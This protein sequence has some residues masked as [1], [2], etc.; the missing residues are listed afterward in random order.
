VRLLFAAAVAAAAAAVAAAAAAA[1]AA[2]VAVAAAA[3]AAAAVAAAAVAAAAVAAASTV[4]RGKA[5]SFLS[6]MTP[7]FLLARV[8]PP[9]TA[10]TRGC[11]CFRGCVCG[12]RSTGGV[13]C[14]NAQRVTRANS[15]ALECTMPRQT[16]G[17]K[18]V[19]I[20]VAAQNGSLPAESLTLIALCSRNNFGRMEELVRAGCVCV[21]FH[22][23]RRV[24]AR[25][26]LRVR[27][28]SP[29]HSR[30]FSLSAPALPAVRCG[31]P[32]FAWLYKAACYCGI[33]VAGPVCPFPPPDFLH[34]RPQCLPCPQGAY[35]DGGLAP[36]VALEG[37]YNLDGVGPDE[38]PPERLA[39]PFCD[40]VVPCEPKEACVGNNTCG[41]GCVG[42]ADAVCVGW[43]AQSAGGGA[44][45][46][47]RGNGVGMWGVAA[48][49]IVLPQTPPPP[50]LCAAGTSPRLPVS[51]ARHATRVTA[52]RPAQAAARP[53]TAAAAS[54]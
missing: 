7:V 54:A 48:A 22:S 11:V 53:T 51:A 30:L 3:V 4:A 19:T 26:A 42:P 41:R 35:C 25:S 46:C 52:G 12:V 44:W 37:W 24:P 28:D 1:V 31:E 13:E 20:S 47:R 45:A 36:P 38:C 18:N 50:L 9:P 27:M 16:V 33:A 10:H 34:P 32:W 15:P 17:F 29:P 49:V 2:A 14:A 43:R 40:Y 23:R 39:R 6:T 8:R 5:G 21:G